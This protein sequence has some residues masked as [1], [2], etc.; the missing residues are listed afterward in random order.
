MIAVVMSFFSFCL[1]VGVLLG[2]ASALGVYCVCLGS[3][4]IVCLCGCFNDRL[5]VTVFLC[6][7]WL[8][9]MFVT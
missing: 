1:C 9:V 3:L 8:C 6:I 5:A 4:L 7:V 2:F